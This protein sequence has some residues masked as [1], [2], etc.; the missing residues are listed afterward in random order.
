MVAKHGP[1]DTAPW[2]GLEGFA[3]KTALVIMTC[4]H[5]QDLYCLLRGLVSIPS[6]PLSLHRFWGLPF[7]GSFL[8]SWHGVVWVFGLR[9]AT[10]KKSAQRCQNLSWLHYSSSYE[11]YIGYEEPQQKD[12]IVIVSPGTII[13][14]LLAHGPRAQDTE[15]SISPISA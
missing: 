5:S 11:A 1:G 12:F 10:R 14:M 6:M 3:F 2:D 13:V 8:S 7:L 4:R 9:D 15:T